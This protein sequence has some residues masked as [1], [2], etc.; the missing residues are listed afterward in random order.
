MKRK[1]L[2]SSISCL[3]IDVMDMGFI[4]CGQQFCLP[5]C[6]VGNGKEKKDKQ[7]LLVSTFI[8]NASVAPHPHN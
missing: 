6:L 3:T 2:S 7:R 1:M 5:P 4:N 8:T